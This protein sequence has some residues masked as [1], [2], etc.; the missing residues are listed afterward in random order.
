M[1]SSM[2]RHHHNNLLVLPWAEPGKWVYQNADAHSNIVVC[3]VPELHVKRS[4]QNVLRSTIRIGRSIKPN[5]CLITWEASAAIA[6]SFAIRLTGA[7]NPWVALGIIPKVASPRVNGLLSTSLK[8]ASIVTCFSQA[9]IP[10]LETLTGLRACDVTPTVWHQPVYSVVKKSKSWASVGA[11]NRDDQTLALAAENCGITVDRFTRSESVFSPSIAW[12]V[13]SPAQAIDAAFHTYHNHLA[14]L[15]S[16]EYASG[17]SIAV[18][19]GFARQ[20]L[21]ATDTPHMRELI[22]NGENGLL[23]RCG[24]SDHLAYVIRSVM[25]GDVDTDRL[26]KSLY[27][28]CREDHTYPVLR[29]H[30]DQMVAMCT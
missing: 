19:A 17:L 24:D 11:S 8:R 2:A 9:D 13:N 21:I 22:I 20:L 15:K 30:I 4:I 3:S 16:T 27:E 26:S 25:Q 28:V 23:V 18:R 1:E 29:R 6:T 7:K 10:T 5:D 14:V 12:F